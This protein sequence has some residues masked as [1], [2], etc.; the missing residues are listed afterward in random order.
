MGYEAREGQS[1]CQV[2][3]IAIVVVAVVAIFVLVSFPLALASFCTLCTTIY[4][5]TYILPRISL[6][7]RADVLG[8]SGQLTA[9]SRSEGRVCTALQEVGGIGRSLRV[10][11]EDQVR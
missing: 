2:R 9:T 4:G 1:L 6:A 3:L 11:D 8:Q 5:V 10:A 7:P